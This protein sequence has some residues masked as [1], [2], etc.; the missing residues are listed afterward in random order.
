MEKQ[1]EHI[2]YAVYIYNIYI[3]MISGLVIMLY[4]PV[5]DIYGNTT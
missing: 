4:L 1:Y 2:V 3:Y 5:Y